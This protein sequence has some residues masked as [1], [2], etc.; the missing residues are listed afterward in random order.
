MQVLKP[1]HYEM[2]GHQNLD[3]S[4]AL[5]EERPNGYRAD[6]CGELKRTLLGH[7]VVRCFNYQILT[8]QFV[9][10]ACELVHILYQTSPGGLCNYA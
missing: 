1:E 8:F 4:A 7:L 10:L 3:V 5:T 6:K 9:Q 2:L